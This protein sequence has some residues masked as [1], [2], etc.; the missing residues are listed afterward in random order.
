MSNWYRGSIT[1]EQFQ[2]YE[3]VRVGGL[4]NMWDTRRVSQLSGGILT[5]DTAL[6]ILKHYRDLNLTYPEVCQSD[7]LSGRNSRRA[8]LHELTHE[9]NY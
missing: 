7:D 2:A 6:E 3:D 9:E 5:M 8:K 4:T 1:E